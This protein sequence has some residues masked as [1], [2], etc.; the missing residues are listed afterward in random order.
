MKKKT[1]LEL[2]IL[3]FACM[4]VLC[5]CEKQQDSPLM[6][7]QV[8]VACYNQSDTFLSELLASFKEHPHRKSGRY[9]KG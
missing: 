1:V 4:Q 5:G 3:T 2:G 9:T 6:T 8:G 7:V